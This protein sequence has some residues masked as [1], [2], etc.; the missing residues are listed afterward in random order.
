MIYNNF[1]YLKNVVEKICKICG[2]KF[3]VFRCREK[4]AEYCSKRCKC[5]GTLLVNGKP[6]NAC[7]KIKIKCKACNKALEVIPARAKST[8]FCSKKCFDFFQKQNVGS[9]NPNWKG[10][11]TIAGGY[12]YATDLSR[13]R[14]YIAEHV[15]VAEK[16]LGRFLTKKEVIH[17]INEVKSDNRLENLY[18]F[19]GQAEH[20]RY[21]NLLRNNNCKRI[22]KSNLIDRADVWGFKY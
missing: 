16:A 14:A 21:H 4:T 7:E 19:S 15:L 2:K 18:L 17:H 11:R 1:L 8:K 10:G 20:A 3:K 5:L 6:W 9:K 12:V 22:V 13:R